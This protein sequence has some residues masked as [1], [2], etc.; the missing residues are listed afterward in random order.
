MTYFMS[1]ED[2]GAYKLMK[3]LM[4]PVASHSTAE[5]LDV[6]LDDVVLVDL[7][8]VEVVSV[9]VLV[10]LVEVEVLVGLAEVEVVDVTRVLEDELVVAVPGMHWSVCCKPASFVAEILNKV[11]LTVPVVV[12]HANGTGGAFR[13]P[14]VA[15]AAALLPQCGLIGSCS[16][17]RSRGKECHGRRCDETSHLAFGAG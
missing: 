12:I 4:P 8:K 14:C 3:Y 15:D 16:K 5:V 11:S 10:G 13:R 6:A 7:V 9:V 2:V 1:G 17:P